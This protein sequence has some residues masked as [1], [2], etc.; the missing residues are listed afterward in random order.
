MAKIRKKR[1]WLKLGII[2]QYC[3]D[4]ETVNSIRAYYSREEQYSINFEYWLHTACKTKDGVLITVGSRKFL[5]HPVLGTV[6]KE[7][8]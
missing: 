6:I 1:R 5:L 4:E 2:S 8:F 7:V 3:T